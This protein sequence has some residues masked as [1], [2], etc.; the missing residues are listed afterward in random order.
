LPGIDWRLEVDRQ[1]A[2]RY[3]TDISSIGS[4]IQL[5]TNGIMLGDYRP[6]NVDDEVDI[7]VRFPENLRNLSQL[8]RLTVNTLQGS[9][10][11]SNFV[12][13]VPAMR[14][15]SLERTDG[16]RV[17]KIAADVE[18]D[19]SVDEH[20]EKLEAW[21]LAGGVDPAVFVNFRGEQ[22]D[23]AESEEFLRNAFGV[24]IFLI[25]IV[26][27]IQFNSFFQTLLILTA[28]VFSTVGVFL[29][30]LITGQPF[31]IVMCGIGVI[32]LA[33]IIVSNNIVLIDAGFV[34]DGVQPQLRSGEPQDRNRRPFYSMVVTA[35][36]R[37]CRWFDVCHRAYVGPDAL[38]VGDGGGM[39]TVEAEP[40][41]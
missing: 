16:V 30:L 7:R 28:I 25:A 19:I 14:V 38:H 41:G 20:V 40:Q 21:V 13:R 27:I 17:M 11:V 39:G 37:H 36:D 9:V 24:A 31:G 4:A 29:S 6:D 3:G 26:L 15:G 32:S 23:Q 5:V 10:P 8:D 22:E 12:T 18:E 35:F 34:A 33:G 2:A 1:Q